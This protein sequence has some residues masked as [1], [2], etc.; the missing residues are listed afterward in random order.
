[1]DLDDPAAEVNEDDLAPEDVLPEDDEVG[2]DANG[3]REAAAITA[4]RGLGPASAS[5]I[6]KHIGADSNNVSTRLR[7][8]EQAGK[9][10]RTGRMI[11]PDRQRGGPQVEWELMPTNGVP[12]DPAQALIGS[13]PVEDR[14]RR[15]GE[16][17]AK[18]N[19]KVETLE[20]ELAAAKARAD[21]SNQRAR[22]SERR[23]QEAEA[24][25][26]RAAPDVMAPDALVVKRHQERADKAE[27]H[28]TALAR[29]LHDVQAQV[30][31]LTAAAA[32]RPATAEGGGI[33]SSGMAAR[34]FDLLL[35][36]A[37]A[38]GVEE[39]VYDRIERLIG[40]GDVDG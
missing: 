19:G 12:T 11:N 40:M 25:A 2:V 5:E 26:Q 3:R 24:R 4:L 33:Q 14:I 30:T 31:K 10:R 22:E 8:L 15:L 29:Q 28:A 38:D 17:V 35:E 9:V 16:V 32:A 6:A 39:H 27:E 23:R 34:Y 13:G 1:M 21:Q 37:R 7:Q 18:A 36:Q 20:N